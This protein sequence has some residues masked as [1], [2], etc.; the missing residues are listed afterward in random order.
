MEP[1]LRKELWPFLLRIYPWQSTLE[2]RETIR[3]DLFLEYQNLR[4]KTQERSKSSKQH[5][6]TVEN[7][8][9]KDVV[10]TD[11]KNPYYSGENNPNIETM[12][13]ILLN[14]ATAYPHV[15][16]IQGMSDLLAPLLSTIRDEA[17]TYWCFTG[18]M[19]QTVF[20]SSPKGNEGLME[21]NLEYLRELL[22]L[23]AFRSFYQL[24]S[25]YARR[26]QKRRCS[27][28]DREFPEADALHIWEACWAQ[29]RTNFFHL[30]VCC[31]IVSIYGDDVIAQRLPHDEILLYFSSLAMHM[32]GRLVLKKA[33]G[34]LHHFSRRE[35]I[36][37]TLVGL[38]TTE[39]EQ[40]DSHRVKQRYECNKSHG[41]K[42][43]HLNA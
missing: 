33:R 8:I 7:T 26:R 41:N 34:L 10:R 24:I 19:Q 22:K 3:N 42:P 2:Q 35:T 31:A 36:P 11:R 32:D 1:G 15:N 5:W 9:L 4:K 37:C 21:I 18:L 39:L 20:S 40:W 25:R 16:Y 30:F 29:Y 17:D 12:K 6:S 27:S 23:V 13:N 28:A 14:Y 38:C 43:C